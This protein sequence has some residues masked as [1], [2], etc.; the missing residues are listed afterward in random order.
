MTH[1]ENGGNV[2]KTHICALFI[3]FL[4]I[5]VALS[6]EPL[7]ELRTQ[8][9]DPQYSM[10]EHVSAF[11]EIKNLDYPEKCSDL[12]KA[13]SL[14]S[15]SEMTEAMKAFILEAFSN[16]EK[17]YLSRQEVIELIE[18][19][20]HLYYFNQEEILYLRQA[21]L[22]ELN[23]SAWS[24]KDQRMMINLLGYMAA[25]FK[26]SDYRNVI[27]RLEEIA[28]DQ[29]NS[30]DFMMRYSAIESIGRIIK[31]YKKEKVLGGSPWIEE[32]NQWLRNTYRYRETHAV[33][34]MKIIIA[35]SFTQSEQNKA[36]L[37]NE[38]GQATSLIVKDE[39][40]KALKRYDS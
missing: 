36:F 8:F 35:I 23:N 38:L 28:V 32:I 40:Q 18:Y 6:K 27:Q 20:Y 39:I 31:T 15:K 24:K 37:E 17:V 34:R 21:F 12:N 2:K 3:I 26:L 11:N 29:E 22:F 33:V 16:P 25:D 7:P 14:Y 10:E 4:T 19:A 5:S 9:L 1:V 13:M 30:E